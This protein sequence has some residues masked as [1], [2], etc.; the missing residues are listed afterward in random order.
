MDND[1]E[2]YSFHSF[3]RCILKNLPI[4]VLRSFAT[5][6]ELGGYTQ[7][8]EILGR[9]QPALSLQIKRLEELISTNIF[10]RKNQKLVLTEEGSKLLGYAN[11]ILEMNDQ[12]V[13]SFVKPV[14]SGQIH[15]GIPGEFAPKLLPSVV[16]LFTRHHP[17]ISL[18]VTCDLSKNLLSESALNKFDVILSLHDD[19]ETIQHERIKTDE[20]VWVASNDFNPN[21]QS[22]LQLVA[23]PQG[24]KYRR[25]ATQ[26]L[27]S[28]RQ[29]WKIAYTIPDI[30]G[31]Q[32]ILEEGLG[33]TVLAKSI[34]PDHL[35]II[36]PSKLFPKLGNI[37]ICITN[38]DTSNVIANRLADYIKA[39]FM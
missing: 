18:K 11:K 20:L 24:C 33:V 19:P 13:S 34:V 31:I 39:D 17:G 12:A 29:P 14:L 2:H 6:A 16:R 36:E 25:R 26:T 1:F 15:L 5:I 32:A 8:V 3:R 22:T 21:N 23:A 35:Q 38:K 7:A 10:I 9:S 27:D 28:I 30:S 37:D 4:D